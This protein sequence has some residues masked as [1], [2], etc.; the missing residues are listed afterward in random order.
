MIDH[1]LLIK[2]IRE[3]K[4]RE[5]KVDDDDEALLFK[6]LLHYITFSFQFIRYQITRN[7]F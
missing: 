4:K 7:Y 3:K 6:L 5:K 1:L 2:S